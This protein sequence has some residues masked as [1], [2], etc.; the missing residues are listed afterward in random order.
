MK[1]FNPPR[2]MFVGT[3]SGCGKT[4]VTVSVLKALKNKNMNVASFKC[5][6]DYI[7]PMFHSKVLNVPSRNL[8]LHL[9]S[10]NTVKHLFCENSQGFD[11]SI[12]EG[13]MGMY[14]GRGTTSECS[15]NHLSVVTSTP[16]ILVLNPKGTSISCLAT[17]S[18][19]LNFRENNLQGVILNQVSKHMFS[20]YKKM[21]EDEFDIKVFGY[22]KKQDDAVFESRHLGLITADEVDDIQS[23]IDILALNCAETVDLD[24][25]VSLSKTALPLE[26]E[27]IKIKKITADTKIKVAV[28]KD[29]AFCFYYQDNL[30]LLEKLGAEIVFFSPLTDKTLP[31][32]INGII[33]G[34]GYPEVYAKELS[35]NT[36]MLLSISN[37]LNKKVPTIAECGGYMYLCSSISDKN[38]DV[39]PMTSVINSNVHMTSKL[40]RFGYINMT[41]LEDN[42]LCKKGD[43]FGAHEFHYSD[44]TDNGNSFT[45]EKYNKTNWVSGHSSEFLYAGYPHLHFYSNTK[46]A[47]NFINKCKEQ[48]IWL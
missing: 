16:T 9:C 28:A 43:V 42:L 20:F 33:L 35:E 19:Y 27:P 38:G 46:L 47:E 37:A 36:S 40:S 32:N 2:L 24:A 22:I 4:T 5:G 41:A 23:K 1:Q 31:A 15:S 14:D 13:V 39:F 44:S 45:A 25:L 26:C 17:I 8:D 18:G 10:E 3:G 12:I 21:I 11:I 29:N 48:C 7:D 30:D 6:P 34:G